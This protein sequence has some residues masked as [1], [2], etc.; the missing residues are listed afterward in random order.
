MPPDAADTGASSS[1]LRRVSSDG[2]KNTKKDVGDSG[3]ASRM[4]SSAE[5][6]VQEAASRCNKPLE[7]PGK[8][9]QIRGAR[10]TDSGQHNSTNTGLFAL[11]TLLNLKGKNTDART[12]RMARDSR[13]SA[14]REHSWNLEL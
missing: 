7:A 8:G 10:N 14:E 5:V 11:P 9:V 13:P 3:Y 12:Q 1:R 4:K 2:G 6:V